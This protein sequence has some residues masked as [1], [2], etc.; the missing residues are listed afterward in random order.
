MSGAQELLRRFKSVNQDT[1]TLTARDEEQAE[2]AEFAAIQAKVRE[3]EERRCPS[4]RSIPRFFQPKVRPKVRADYDREENRDDRSDRNREDKEN[5]DEVHS[6]LARVEKEARIRLLQRKSNEEVLEEADLH[7]IIELLK[8]HAKPALNNSSIE[9]IDYNGFCIIR[10]ELLRRGERFRQFFTAATFI[11]FEK[12]E[13]GLMRYEHFFTFVVRQVQ[14]KHARVQL[15]LYDTNGKGYLTENDMEIFIFELIPTMPQLASL[16]EEMHPFY[17]FT[18]VRK[19]FFFLDQKRT[20]RIY[21]RDLL[22]AQV[23]CELY[24]LRSQPSD[25]SEAANNWFTNE[26]A[27]R[28]YGSYL[29]LDHDQNGMLSKTELR[30]FGRGML[31]DVFMDRLF[32]EYQTYPDSE[33][34]VREMDY[35]H[36][37]EF[38]LA[39]DN[40]DTEQ[41]ISYFWKIIDIDHNGWIDGHV[42]N[43]F[44]DGIARM[45]KDTQIEVGSEFHVPGS[46]D[47]QD[48]I[49]DMVRPKK[50]GIITL[51]DLKECRQGGMILKMLIDAAFF[52]RYEHREHLVQELDDDD[53]EDDD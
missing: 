48:E 8:N 34:G 2:E 33:T 31:T 19:F 47:V 16:P 10:D 9:V 46:A 23:L 49:F 13:D 43:Y 11:K 1:R 20:G 53:D 3:E 42:I 18:A 22:F 14:Q 38:V 26:S 30:Q 41:G 32:Q 50:H 12:G 17:V 37:N 27:M 52:W 25:P 45:L 5:R 40:I 21:I 28:L 51:E 35:K 24:E 7:V 4:Y 6:L 15:S 36:F 44:F 29:E 39:M